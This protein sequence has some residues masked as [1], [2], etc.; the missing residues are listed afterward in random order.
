MGVA[1]CWR[2][3]HDGVDLVLRFAGVN[4][5]GKL[6]HTQLV[7]KLMASCEKKSVSHSPFYRLGMYPRDSRIDG[8]LGGGCGCTG[9]SA[10][11]NNSGCVWIRDE[12]PCCRWSDG[13]DTAWGVVTRTSGVSLL[14]QFQM[15]FL[16][17]IRGVHNGRS[18]HDP[19]DGGWW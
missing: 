12:M 6:V 7:R 4:T 9:G 16:C 2:S 10:R 11:C 17:G 1:I 8:R 14:C 18:I 19:L 5:S 3:K 13:R 15:L